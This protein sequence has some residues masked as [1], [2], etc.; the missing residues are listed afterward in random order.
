MAGV[1]HWAVPA[2]GRR[3]EIELAD[4]V[5][6][7][8]PPYAAVLAVQNYYRAHGLD[9]LGV[10]PEAH[11]PAVYA[12]CE[13]FLS[14]EQRTAFREQFTTEQQIFVVSKLYRIYQE[15]RDGVP[16][17]NPGETAT[18]DH[19]DCADPSGPPSA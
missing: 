14:A 10:L 5:W 11:Q 3:H 13:D 6:R 4:D 8:T 9:P 16:R 19:E 2:V 12:L 15:I 1:D 17:P 18:P 7:V